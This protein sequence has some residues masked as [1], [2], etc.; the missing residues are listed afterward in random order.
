MLRSENYLQSIQMVVSPVAHEVVL[1]NGSDEERFYLAENRNLSAELWERFYNL[2]KSRALDVKLATDADVLRLGS[3]P[4]RVLSLLLANARNYEQGRA[5]LAESDP[6]IFEGAVRVGLHGLDEAGVEE[7]VNSPL[8][9]NKC[10][11]SLVRSSCEI[12]EVMLGELWKRLAWDAGVM[13]SSEEW[14]TLYAFFKRGLKIDKSRAARL[15]GG[16]YGW[17]GVRSFI[18]L[19]PETFDEVLAEKIRRG[20]EEEWYLHFLSSRYVTTSIVKKA[21]EYVVSNINANRDPLALNNILEAIVSSPWITPELRLS[22]ARVYLK[23]GY[24]KRK[25]E[26]FN[27][28]MVLYHGKEYVRWV[29]LGSALAEGVAVG[30][31]AL[32]LFTSG[33]EL[34]FAELGDLCRWV[35]RSGGWSEQESLAKLLGLSVGSRYPV[36]VAGKSFLSIEDERYI[37]ELGERGWLL[38]INLASS[39]NGGVTDLLAA[40]SGALA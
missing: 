9:N 33:D 32:G 20:G 35:E 7:L 6:E 26:L 11:M 29:D 1:L 4:K 5:I 21:L 17:E 18:E 13:K 27:K 28:G 3:R 12:S 19:I 23:R 10:A 31:S 25:R 40:I 30:E 2:Y 22:A 16:L 39:W 36:R 8:F 38:F 34:S 37:D 15:I 14:D 24:A